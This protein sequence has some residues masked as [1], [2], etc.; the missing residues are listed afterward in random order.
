VEQVMEEIG[1][2]TGE[3]LMAAPNKQHASAAP[4]AAVAQPAAAG[5]DTELEER[6]NALRR[7]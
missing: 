7:A 5:V 6:L 2:S 1:I 4:E 3:Q